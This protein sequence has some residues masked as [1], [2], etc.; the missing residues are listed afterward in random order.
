MN[1]NVYWLLK[2]EDSE[3]LKYAIENFPPK[4]FYVGNTKNGKFQRSTIINESL[5]GRVLV[6]KNEGD[7]F[8]FFI[9]GYEVYNLNNNEKSFS[10][11]Y[12]LNEKIEEDTKLTNANYFNGDYIEITFSGK[13]EVEP[14]VFERAPEVP[15]YRIKK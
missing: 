3:N 13:I 11:R 4:N 15:F 14:T 9:D 10:L 8:L 7:G 5:E 2:E 1:F 12:K 6:F